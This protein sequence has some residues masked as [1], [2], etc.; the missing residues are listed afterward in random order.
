[1]PCG[2]RLGNSLE[3]GLAC[4]ALPSSPRETHA[5]PAPVP[6]GET[7]GAETCAKPSWNR[8]TRRCANCLDASCYMSAGFC[9]GCTVIV[10]PRV[11]SH[12]YSQRGFLL[13]NAAGTQAW[14]PRCFLS[15]L[16]SS[17][18]PSSLLPVSALAAWRG[19]DVITPATAML[20]LPRG[21]R[22][23]AAGWVWGTLVSE[24]AGAEHSGVSGRLPAPPT[25]RARTSVNCSLSPSSNFLICKITIIIPIVRCFCES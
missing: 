11:A 8:P 16:P 3:V 25:G 7:Q 24:E 1:M 18:L 5:G 20:F 21:G 15:L 6:G 14:T 19:A 12:F 22:R 13:E 9:A 4:W 2:Q 10:W 23:L 17:L